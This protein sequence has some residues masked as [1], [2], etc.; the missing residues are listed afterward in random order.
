[1]ALFHYLAYFLDHVIGKKLLSVFYLSY[2]SGAS[3]A[4]LLC[5]SSST[6]QS[7][8]DDFQKEMGMLEA[9]LAGLKKEFATL[10]A[11]QKALARHME[12]VPGQIKRVQ[13]DVSL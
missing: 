3:S 11:D 13:E 12:S 10:A 6:Q 9:Q 4:F 7:L 2:A 5:F 1:M 8:M